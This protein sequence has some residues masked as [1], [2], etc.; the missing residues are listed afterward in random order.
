MREG[1]QRDAQGS[2][3][4]PLRPVRLG[5]ADVVLERKPDGTILIRSPQPLDAYPASSP[6]GWSIGPRPRPTACSWRSAR[7]TAT[8]A[9]S[10]YAAG[11]RRRCARIGAGAARARALRRAAD[12]DPVRQRH[13]ARAA[14]R[15]P[16]CIVGVPYAPISP[17]YSLMSSDFGKLRTI[18]D[19]LTPGLVF[20]SDGKPF[21]RA[22][23]AAVPRDVELVVD[24]QSAG[25]AARRRRS[26]SCSAPTPT[27][28]R[29][30]RAR[31]G[32][33]PTRSPSSCSPPARPACPRA[34]STPSACCARTRR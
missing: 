20:A 6:S 16:R 34:S 8:G 3:R 17:A 28:A 33:R 4:A 32:R 25:R 24:A 23:A 18:I 29:R 10:T 31:R 2:R 9:R 30:R 11:A 27:A 1:V 14:R 12:R 26:P 13:R 19:L 21:A 22:I 5:P 15:S 7:R